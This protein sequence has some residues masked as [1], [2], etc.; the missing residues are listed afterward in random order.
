MPGQISEITDAAQ[1][2]AQVTVDGAARE[3]SLAMLGVDGPNGAVVGDWV[4]VHLGFALAKVD[5]AEAK[6][7][8]DSLAALNDMYERELTDSLE[9]SEVRSS[10]THTEGLTHTEG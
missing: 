5:E 10:P 1:L 4:I 8:L 6:E 7:T 9:Q 3:V 2:R